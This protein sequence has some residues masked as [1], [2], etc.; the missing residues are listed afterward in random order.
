MLREEKF[1]PNT[2][3]VRQGDQGDKLYFIVEGKLEAEKKDPGSGVI[4]KVLEYKEG[5]YFGEIALIKDTVRQASI[6]ATS[7]CVLLSIS[8]D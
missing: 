5:D 6:K 7:K 8:R 4:Q 1:E 3:V 2:Y